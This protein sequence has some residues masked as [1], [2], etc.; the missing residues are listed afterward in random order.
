MKKR[1]PNTPFNSHLNST[2]SQGVGRNPTY[3]VFRNVTSKKCLFASH[4]SF[5]PAAV[6]G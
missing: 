5:F 2:Q 4:I 1:L 6:R 3:L